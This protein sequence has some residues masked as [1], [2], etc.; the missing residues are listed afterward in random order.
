[1]QVVEDLQIIIARLEESLRFLEKRID[2]Q[3]LEVKNLHRENAKQSEEIRDAGYLA[4][5]IRNGYEDFKKA[6]SNKS[7]CHFNEVSKFRE[8][9]ALMHREEI[10]P[11]R[12]AIRKASTNKFVLVVQTITTTIL[13][14]L[15]VI[16]S[17]MGWLKIGG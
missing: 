13:A 10:E 4:D 7:L 16:G 6:C 8:E 14:V 2:Q 1:M 3:D 9:L 12:D 5:T 11:L 15:A 17:L